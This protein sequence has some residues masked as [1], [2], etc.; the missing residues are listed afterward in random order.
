[1]KEIYIIEDVW[2]YIKIFLFHNINIHGKHLENNKYI[3][4]YNNII[5]K[6]PILLHENDGIRIVYNSA[7]VPIRIVKF[8]YAIKQKN[9]RKLIIEYLIVNYDNIQNIKTKRKEIREEYYKNIKIC[10]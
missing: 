3:K 4:K 8:I 2:R 9:I 5:K 1:M 7:L 6:I 10:G